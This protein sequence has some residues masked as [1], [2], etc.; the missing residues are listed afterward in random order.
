MTADAKPALTA[1]SIVIRESD[2]VLELYDGGRLIRSFA[3]V[4]GFSPDLDKER[5][6]DGRTPEGDYRIEVKNPESAFHLSLGLSYPGPKDAEK[7]LAAGLITESERDEIVAA[8]EN[9]TMPPQKTALGGEI[10]IHG[11]GCAGDWTRGCVALANDEMTELFNLV[12]IGTTV[13]IEP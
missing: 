1:P 4:L 3:I 9:G 5:E 8:A 2:R 11:G 6:G 10:Y 13:N 7:G 12:S